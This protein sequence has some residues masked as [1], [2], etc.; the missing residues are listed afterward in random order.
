[1]VFDMTELSI[2][3][4]LTNQLTDNEDWDPAGFWSRIR[5]GFQETLRRVWTEQPS[6]TSEEIISWTQPLQPGLPLPENDTITT[7][8]KSSKTLVLSDTDN[9]FQSVLH[10]LWLAGLCDKH[11]CWI[12]E[13]KNIHVIHTGDWLNKWNPNPHVLDGLKRLKETVPEGCH[14]TLLNGNHE[15]SI[16]QMADQGLKT[17]LTTE[18]LDFIRQQDVIHI[19]K[20]TLFLHGY[21]TLDLL[22]I[23]KQFQREEIFGQGCNN[24][25]KNLFFEGKYPLFRESQGLRII[26]DV[27]NPKLYYN[28]KNQSGYPRGNYIGR[29]LEELKIKTI[30]HGHKPTNLTQLDYEL[31]AFIPGIRLINNDNHIRQ[32]GLGG[33]ILS[34]QSVLFIN[35]K[36]QREAGSLKQLRKKVRKHLQTRKQDIYGKNWKKKRI[37]E[38]IRIAA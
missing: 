16:L 14:L 4:P 35:P 12:P 6:P 36:T 24:R 17:S 9:D 29:L 21:P 15:L 2:P 38:T 22:M 19:D 1:M 13:I 23:L 3:M 25:L 30:I 18:D 27:K 10:I 34:D 28:Q 7:S 8:P 20:D 32:N 37:K 31:E 33:V 5:S 26:G 11:G